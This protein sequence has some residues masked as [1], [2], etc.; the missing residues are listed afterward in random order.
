MGSSFSWPHLGQGLNREDAEPVLPRRRPEEPCL[1]GA[2]PREEGAAGG[3][4]PEVEATAPAEEGPLALGLAGDSAR[5]E[6]WAGW[7]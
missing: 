2:R 7:S 5:R 6:A 3:C 1:V 4:E